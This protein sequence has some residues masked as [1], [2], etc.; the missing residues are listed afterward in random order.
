MLLEV[1]NDNKMSVGRVVASVTGLRLLAG[2]ALGNM[3]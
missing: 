3:S 2:K 1:L